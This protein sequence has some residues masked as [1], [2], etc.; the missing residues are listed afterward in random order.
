MRIFY[1]ETPLEIPPGITLF[2]LKRQLK[3]DADIVILNGYPLSADRLLQAEDHISLIRRGEQPSADDLE[4]LMA[5]RHTP[6]VHQRL[7]SSCVGV[8]GVGGLGS[9]VA[10]AL[11]RVGVGQ[12]II[13]DFDIVEPSNLNRQQYFIDQIGMPKVEALRDN[14]QRINPWTRITAHNVKI[15]ST[16]LRALFASVDVLAEAFD[17]ADQKAFL[18][19][20]FLQ[21]LPGKPLVAASGMAG[22]GPANTIKTC[23]ITDNF[24]LC[25]DGSAA[26]RPGCGLMAP[27]VGIVAHHQANAIV[28]L[29]LNQSPETEES[30]I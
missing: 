16:N 30:S 9:Q 18:A 2:Q 14:L 23:K 4:Q 12:L 20:C 17:A 22:F 11:A 3:P 10:I 26:A 19:S 1:N 28:R 21:T 6:G 8:A 27:R 15:T 29:L 7:K 5:A 13:A 25:G 24:Y